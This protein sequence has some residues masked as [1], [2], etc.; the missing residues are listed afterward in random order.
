MDLY[1]QKTDLFTQYITK[2]EHILLESKPF[3]CKICSHILTFWEYRFFINSQWIYRF[4]NP[5]RIWFE[6]GLFEKAPGI[7][8]RGEPTS[9]YS[10]FSGYLWNYAHCQKCG[11]HIG[12]FYENKERHCF[13]GLIL[14]N[15]VF[16]SSL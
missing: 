11:S 2:Q 16:D 12:W 1:F 3:L 13:Y 9:D 5:H 15:M 7:F 6:I 4:Q 14:E 10:W 8:T